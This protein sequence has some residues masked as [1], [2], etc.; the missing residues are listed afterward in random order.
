[1]AKPELGQ[2][3][4]FVSTYFMPGTVPKAL[5]FAAVL[6]DDKVNLYIRIHKMEATPVAQPSSQI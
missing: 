6:R 4:S 2:R 1:M 5:T 3:G